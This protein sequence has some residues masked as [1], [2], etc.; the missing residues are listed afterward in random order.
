ML[1][2]AG[3][4]HLS[5][6]P[7]LEAFASAGYRAVAWD[8]PGYGYSAPVEPFTFMGLARRCIDLIEALKCDDVSLLGHSMGGMVAQEVALRR[9]DLVKRLI[10]CGTSAGFARRSDGTVAEDWAQRFVDDRTRLLDAGEGMARLAEQLVPAMVGPQA[11]A[12]GVR[13]AMHCLAEVPEATYRRAL[14]CITTFDRQ[15]ALG[16]LSMPVLLVGGSNDRVAPPVYMRQMAQ[17]MP[18]AR[19]EEI[20][21]A[22][23]L[24]HLE[25]PEA[26]N[27]CVLSFLREPVLGAH[28]GLQ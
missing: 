1:H 20:D 15:S 23:H 16:H 18:R 7:Q 8:M 17:A 26:F 24:M 5:F 25:A 27:A 4:G 12:E 3:G 13:M 6:S 2:G 22:G 11:E 10:L 21:G 14:E 28:P 19:Y 9:P